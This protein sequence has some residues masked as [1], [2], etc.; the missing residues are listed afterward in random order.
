MT[1]YFDKL[2]KIKFYIFCY[3]SHGKMKNNVILGHVD[4]F[5]IHWILLIKIHFII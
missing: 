4:F 1:E 3:P 2:L 5:G